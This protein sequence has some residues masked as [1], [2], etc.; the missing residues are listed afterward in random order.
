M[1]VE[2]TIMSPHLLETGKLLEVTMD[3]LKPGTCHR[4]GAA[5]HFVHDDVLVT[6]LWISSV[7]TAARQSTI[8]TRQESAFQVATE[9]RKV[10]PSSK[11]EMDIDQDDVTSLDADACLTP[12]THILVLVRVTNSEKN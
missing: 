3:C 6:A 7:S 5:I 11:V 8:F 12:C 4:F 9:D 10:G 2:M 1:L